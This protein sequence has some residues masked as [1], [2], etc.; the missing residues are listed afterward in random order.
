M[1]GLPQSCLLHPGQPRTLGDS[2]QD[3]QASEKKGA[4]DTPPGLASLLPVATCD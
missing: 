4:P 1:D 2:G 3:P